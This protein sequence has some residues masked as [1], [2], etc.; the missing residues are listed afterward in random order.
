M[1]PFKTLVAYEGDG[2]ASGAAAPVVDPPAPPA[3]AGGDA[4]RQQH[5]V[6]LVE[7]QKERKSKRALE[8]QL[9][10]AT[11]KLAEAEQAKMT[12]NEQLKAKLAEAEAKATQHEAEQAGAVKANLVRTAAKDFS[13]PEDAIAQLRLAGDLDGIE[14]AD[15]ATAAVK[16]LATAKPYL[17]RA[18][19]T[20]ERATI[21]QILANGRNLDQHTPGAHAGGDD[22]VTLTREQ[23]LGLSVDQMSELMTKYPAKYQ[24]SIEAQKR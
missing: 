18:E 17:L 22:G 21:E 15:E 4:D 3:P 14:T 6:P 8:E 23:L 7:L 9:A 5:T 20:G 13:D 16:A 2:G 12:E 1:F 19:P 24:R 10:A 11:A